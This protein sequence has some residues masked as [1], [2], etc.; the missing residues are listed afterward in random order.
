[1]DSTERSVSRLSGCLALRG[2]GNDLDHSSVSCQVRFCG[3]V[4]RCHGVNLLLLGVLSTRCLVGVDWAEALMAPG[5]A[6]LLLLL[7]LLLQPEDVREYVCVPAR[8]ARPDPDLRLDDREPSQQHQ[9][10]QPCQPRTAC[11]PSLVSASALRVC[12]VASVGRV[13][14]PR[15]PAWPVGREEPGGTGADEATRLDH[16]R[17]NCA[18]SER[19]NP[20]SSGDSCWR[21]IE[22]IRARSPITLQHQPSAP[23]ESRTSAY[24]PS[25]CPFAPGITQTTQLLD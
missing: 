1:M 23:K 2:S 20:P 13:W 25:L 14:S 4:G 12:M 7:L 5:P 18:G 6:P 9:G 19:A 10:R 22:V 24:P 8:F 17:L 11:L 3:V 16:P 21:V 15:W